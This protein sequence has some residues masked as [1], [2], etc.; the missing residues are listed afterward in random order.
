MLKPLLSIRNLETFYHTSKGLIRAVDDVSLEIDEG[1]IVGLVGE[2]GCGKSTLAL[3]I[4][5]LVSDP[6]RIASGEILF[7]GKN[8]LSLSENEMRHIRGKKISVVFQDPVTYLNPIMKIRDQISESIVQ[9]RKLDEKAIYKKVIDI[10]KTVQIGDAASVGESYPHQLS[11][12]MLQRC[13]LAIAMISSPSLIIADEP[14]T[15]VDVTVQEQLL[16]LMKELKSDHDVSFLFVTHDLGIVAELCDKVC[17]MYCGK[18]VEYADVYSLFQNPLHP[19]TQAL[20]ASVLSIDEF[21]EDLVAVPGYVPDLA[22]PPKG[23]PFHPR[24]SK[25]LPICQTRNPPEFH[26]GNGHIVSCWLYQRE[27]RNGT[28]G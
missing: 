13:L 12:G 6:G 5:R 16:K 21:K 14:T 22:N 24:C 2:S 3:S 4:V 8:L 20:L 15:S 19:Y 10:L 11:G 9:H 25:C 27:T 23:C 1:E 26:L 17:I 18:V 7:E 28:R